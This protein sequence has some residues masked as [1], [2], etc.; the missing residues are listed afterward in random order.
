MLLEKYILFF[1]WCCLGGGGG[2][3]RWGLIKIPNGKI[4]IAIWPS[5]DFI[6]V[7]RTQVANRM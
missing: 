6:L 2:G 7:V 1:S 3:G 4:G 5:N